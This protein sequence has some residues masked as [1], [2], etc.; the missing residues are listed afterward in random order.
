MNPDDIDIYPTNGMLW[1][2]R[3][4]MMNKFSTHCV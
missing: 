3:T 2:N 4:G 1:S